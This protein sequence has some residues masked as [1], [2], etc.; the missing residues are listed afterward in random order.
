M[1]GM[2]ESGVPQK[3]MEMPK[4]ICFE[5]FNVHGRAASLIMM[6]HFAGAKCEKKEIT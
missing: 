3:P 4:S 6:T 5:Y 2:C 1:G